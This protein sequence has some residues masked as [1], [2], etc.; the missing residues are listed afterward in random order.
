MPLRTALSY[1]PYY[2]PDIQEKAR[3][4]EPKDLIMADFPW[5]VAWYGHRQCLWL[6]LSHREAAGQRYRNDFYELNKQGKPIGALYLSAR[7]LRTM[8][9]RPMLDWVRRD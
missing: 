1:N 5:A 9:L 7:T 2:P 6:S 3:W 4:M 8:E